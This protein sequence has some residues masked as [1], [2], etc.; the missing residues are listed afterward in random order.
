MVPYS[1]SI[2]SLQMAKAI[3]I[4]NFRTN[5]QGYEYSNQCTIDDLKNSINK[6]AWKMFNEVAGVKFP[7][8]DNSNEVLLPYLLHGVVVLINSKDGVVIDKYGYY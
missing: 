6:T 5:E 2:G 7:K 3:S 4:V 8:Y 1:P